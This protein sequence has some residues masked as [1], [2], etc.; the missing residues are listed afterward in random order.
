MVFNLTRD[1]VADLQEVKCALKYVIHSQ[2][3]RSGLLFNT[4][5]LRKGIM[6]V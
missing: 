4:L 6:Q 3:G 2:V 5:T 1:I